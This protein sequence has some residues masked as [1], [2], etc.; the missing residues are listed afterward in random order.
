MSSVIGDNI[1]VSLFGESHGSVVGAT[2]HG[3]ESGIKIDY[4]FIK[5]QM[6][7]R[8]AN[9]NLSTARVEEDEVKFISGVFNDFTTGAPLTVVIEN[10]NVNSKDY[11]KMFRPSHADYT[12]ELK[13]KGYQDYRGGGHFS[14]RLTAP[15]VA[16]GSIVI[17]ILKNKN[18]KIGS[19]IKNIHNIL[20]D[21]I[22]FNDLDNYFNYVNNEIFPVLNLNKK[23]EMI[24]EIETIKED[25]DSV[26]GI[27]ETV[28]SLPSSI[29]EPFFD[30]LESKIS[31]YLF[32]VPGLKGIEFGL[33]FDFAKYRGKEVNDEL[34][35]D[36]EVRTL[37]NNNGGINGGISNS[38][39]IV[40][41][42]V[43]K[44]TPSI[45]KE[46]RSIDEN[47]NNTILEIKGRHD[48]CIV[49]RARV[50]IDSLVALCLLDL[51]SINEGKKWMC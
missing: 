47:F 37:T 48:P 41:R 20:D 6:N 36:G 33:G 34:V 29:G 51:I 39:P 7:I 50:V 8:K 13:Y 23:E 28:I 5:H 12:Q 19:H 46:Q 31:Q 22:N 26:G 40:F 14:G 11:P 35:N 25:L 44:P 17:S 9:D 10:K 3:L 18:I 21:N 27:I 4:E 2:I 24:K 16:L 45:L 43:L 32:S 15:I 42:C 30:S 1:K 38:M 49:R